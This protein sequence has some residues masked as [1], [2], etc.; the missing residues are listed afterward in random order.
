[1][2]SSGQLVPLEA[3]AEIGFGGGEARVF[4][5]N[6]ER[7]VTISANLSG[8]ESG[9]AYKIVKAASWYENPGQGVVVRQSEGDAEQADI[10]AQFGI[11]LVTGI[12]L[13]Y[14]VL[15][16]LFKDFIM[17][18]TLVSV[19]FLSPAGAIIALRVTNT[20]FSIPVFIGLLMLFGI[21]VKNSILLVDFIIEAQHAGVPRHVAIMD[22]ARKR[23]R[24]IVMTTIAMIA[25]M[26]PAAM[27]TSGPGAFRHGM[28]VA[29]IGGLALSTVLSLVFVPAVYTIMDDL[30]QWIKGLFKAVPTVTSEDRAIAIR[31]DVE[32]RASRSA[33]E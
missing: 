24:P 6:R 21:A 32:R 8:I 26:V 2:T 17:P 31:E 13:I 12:L 14:C 22:A 18:L 1:M 16:L 30:D 4:R 3:V 23:S 25:G 10:A 15:V 29:V 7:I 33:A 20:P 28:A 27:A 11:A 9:E 5:E 19:F